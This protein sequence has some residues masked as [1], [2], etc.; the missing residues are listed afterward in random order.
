MTG[1]SWTSPSRVSRAEQSPY[2]EFR[3]NRKY[4]GVVVLGVPS[5]AALGHAGQRTLPGR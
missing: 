1:S 3:P 5:V 2:I 4:A